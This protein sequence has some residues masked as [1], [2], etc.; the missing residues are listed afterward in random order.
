MSGAP[1]P[2]CNFRCNFEKPETHPGLLSEKQPSTIREL[3]SKDP[4]PGGW[5]VSATFNHP[6]RLCELLPSSAERSPPTSEH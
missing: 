4:A 1:N 2:S 5:E 3:H 6:S